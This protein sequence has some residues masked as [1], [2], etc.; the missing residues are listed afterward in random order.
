MLHA[1]NA[2]VLLLAALHAAR[3]QR[4][5]AHPWAVDA[6]LSGANT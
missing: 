6:S 2:L 5:A 1:V 3:L 4:V